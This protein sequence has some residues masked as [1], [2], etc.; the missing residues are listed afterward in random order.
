MTQKQKCSKCKVTK[1]LDVDFYR[2]PPSRKTWNNGYLTQ[3]KSCVLERNRKSAQKNK[4]KVWENK[5]KYRY[6]IEAQ[7]YK[8]LLK[9]QNG[10]C[11]ICK[12]KNP[13]HKRKKSNY[14]CVDHC[15]KTGK[16]RGLLCATCNTALGLF[17]DKK[18]NLTEAI[19]YLNCFEALL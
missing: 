1:I 9:K 17:Q 5:L 15:H 11:A 10:C 4:H 2:Q 13:S 14:F 6:G 18:E 16:V 3:C 12:T 8:D 19:N 7:D